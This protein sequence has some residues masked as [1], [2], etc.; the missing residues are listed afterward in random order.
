MASDH[1]NQPSLLEDNAPA[2]PSRGHAAKSPLRDTDRWLGMEISHRRLL[3]ALQSG[4]LQ[5]RASQAG[6]LLA[7][8]AFLREPD[9]AAGSY[10]IRLRVKLK[11][12]KLPE[13]RIRRRRPR[14]L[15]CPGAIP[16]FAI[17]ELAVKT[18]EERVR[19]TSLAASFSNIELPA[20]PTV[21][22]S[23]RCIDPNGF[24]PERLPES[25]T[26]G[27][28]GQPKY[29]RLRS[30]QPPEP[31]IPDTV[32]AQQGAM[33]M[34]IW[35]VPRMAPWLDLLVA[36][37]D[38]DEKL[39]TAADKVDAPWCAAPPWTQDA[40]QRISDLGD[41]QNLLWRA[42]VK[43]FAAAGA[44]APGRELAEEIAEEARSCP[45]TAAWLESTRRILRAESTI[46]LDQWQT[47][48]V[49][50]AIQLVL[51]RPKP[52]RFITWLSDMP[53]LPPAI[54]WSAALLCGLLTGYLRLDS[55]FRGSAAQQEA[56]TIHVFRVCGGNGAISWPSVSGRPNWSKRGEN[57]VLLWGER[58][59]AQ[60]TAHSRSN[61]L[62][63]DLDSPD[64][65]RA[66]TDLAK[67][68][69]WPCLRWQISFRKP[70]QLETEKED[71][72]FDGKTL[73]IL[74]P[75]ALHFRHDSS[76]ADVTFEDTLDAEQF[77]HWLAVGPGRVEEPPPVIR[78]DPPATPTT[79]LKAH[80]GKT[81]RVTDVAAEA[82]I[83]PSDSIQ[84]NMLGI[85]GLNYLTDFLSDSEESDLVAVI[86][87]SP[88]SA[89]LKTR[90]VQHYGWR[91]SYRDR[92]VDKSMYLGPLPNWAKELGKRLV[93]LRLLGKIPDQVIV[94]DYH[95]NQ[96]ITWH[97]DAPSFADGIATVSLLASWEMNFRLGKDK[98]TQRLEQRSA[99]IMSGDA[100]YKWKHEIPKR[101]YETNP[102]TNK[103]ELRRRRLSLTFRMLKQ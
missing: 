29:K 16:T 81:G 49:E 53:E 70:C 34:A 2:R 1:P 28:H 23:D 92:R 69:K 89:E 14:I 85:P 9:D 26:P 15:F 82:E 39:Q 40:K 38:G 32:D 27:A 64:M 44:D 88:W 80:I 57:F 87:N 36:S 61:W 47:R 12:A 86:D 7:E 37:L 33:S 18:E 60:W 55:K 67:H 63:A 100:R 62:D 103:K 4:W 76:H 65:R 17:S 46:E 99:L 93:D 51:A 58:E 97:A 96:G 68:L 13:M 91:Y 43:V 45:E 24:E 8:R 71:L 5:P 48:P 78:S 22:T 52:A 66:A 11:A 59:V 94:N 20:E 21:T 75:T 30:E 83:A 72:Q 90:R 77:R 6:H 3:D 73:S 50:T 84:R 10:P 98:R 79:E 35:A 56:L 102:D 95:G 19:L 25:D 42:T 54:W 74:R 31:G 41:S 101:K